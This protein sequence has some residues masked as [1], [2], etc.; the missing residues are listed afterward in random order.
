MVVELR[1]SGG[2]GGFG[3]AVAMA[4]KL[5]VSYFSAYLSFFLAVALKRRA[6][7]VSIR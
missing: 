6:L 7:T 2:G 4:H 5:K 3:V 1:L